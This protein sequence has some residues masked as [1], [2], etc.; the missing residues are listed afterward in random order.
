MSEPMK[1]RITGECAELT[2][3]VPATYADKIRN[4]VNGIVDLLE[5]RDG[6]TANDQVYTV[7]EVFL[8]GI[9]ASEVLRAA[10]Y[11]ESL[12]QQKLPTQVI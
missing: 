4:L 12:T 8:E 11:R 9:K 10:H 7:A 1:V 3:R 5:N 2:F 6:E